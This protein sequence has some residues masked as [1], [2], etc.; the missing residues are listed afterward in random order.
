MVRVVSVRAALVIALAAGT[1]TTGAVHAALADTGIVP[2]DM[3][4]GAVSSDTIARDHVC[5]VP[6]AD[7]SGATVLQPLTVRSSRR[8]SDALSAYAIDVAALSGIRSGLVS[9]LESSPGITTRSQGGYGQHSQIQVRGATPEQTEVMLDGV[10]VNTA[11]G[12]VADI[13]S[14]PL[15]TVG[16]V[17]VHAGE[18]PLEFLGLNG[19]GVVELTSARGEDGVWV[20]AQ[21]GSFGLAK[22][23]A[24]GRWGAGQHEHTVAL[25]AGRCENDYPFMS[26][27]GT[28]YNGTDDRLVHMDNNQYRDLSGRYAWR[29]SRVSGTS[30]HAQL[31]YH[32]QRRGISRAL[33]ARDGDGFV[34]DQIVSAGMSVRTAD[35][36]TGHLD[37][38]IG[39][40]LVWSHYAHE[41]DSIASV[42]PFA[43][44]VVGWG[45]AWRPWLG[46]RALAGLSAES[47]ASENLAAATDA[48]GPR[49]DRVLGR[50]GLECTL[51]GERLSASVKVVALGQYEQQDT[52][53][54]GVALASSSDY[55]DLGV[56][57]AFSAH[58]HAQVSS[59]LACE[60]GGRY[61]ERAPSFF[62]KFGWSQNFHGRSTLEPEKVW[63]GDIGLRLV[64]SPVHAT[65]NGFVS[66][67]EGK[68]KA[69][70]QSQGVFV[71]DNIGDVLSYG[72][73][74]VVSLK[75][76]RWLVVD[77]SLS[78]MVNTIVRSSY[79][80]WAGSDVPLTPRV[81]DALDVRVVA[82]GFELG[83]L[84]VYESGYYLGAQN[85]EYVRSEPVLSAHARYS[86]RNRVEVA[87]LLSNYL[88]VTN[89]DF[90]DS[91][92]AGRTHAVRCALHVGSRNLRNE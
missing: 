15:E 20:N 57:P 61:Q 84:M 11:F 16:Q 59:W 89:Y 36:P 75:R 80:G 43:E 69:T 56:R 45:R 38:S 9:V 34:R 77:N 26:D 19:G 88:D 58:V 2:V 78:V 39:G 21:T 4:A 65:L 54:G 49:S 51:G 41:L 55:S 71:P 90:R 63:Q 13:G 5:A 82:R 6:A 22:V 37:I 17:T 92:K 91:P 29:M 66:S 33:D 50:A 70:M 32:G 8:D 12:A 7:T 62:E 30:V 14:I 3:S 23:D 76:P 44:V 73:E 47:F 25:G 10:P 31:A 42:G 68:I 35:G 85:H 27:N 60:A 24:T 72:G 83:H 81:K 48:L 28:P 18:V 64:S 52:R 1:C 79:A 53:G 67:T 74:C 46:T 87:Y 40:R 86:W